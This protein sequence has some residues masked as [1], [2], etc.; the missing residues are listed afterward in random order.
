MLVK[1][2]DY[3]MYIPS[4]WMALAVAL[5]AVE[6]QD[7]LPGSELSIDAAVGEAQ[8]IVVA[9]AFDIG[10]PI[11]GGSAGVTYGSSNLRISRTLKGGAL[12]QNL[13]L[14]G[15][16]VRSFID[17]PGE[18]APS[19][20]KEYIFFVER[21]DSSTLRGIK[22]LPLTNENLASLDAAQRRVQRLPGSEFGIFEATERANII[23]I[24]RLSELERLRPSPPESEI[25]I[26]TKIITDRTLKGELKGI[27]LP[28]LKIKSGS[29]V[30]AE[31]AP[32]VGRDYLF[33]IDKLEGTEANW[34]KILPLNNENAHIIY[35]SIHQPKLIN[36][37]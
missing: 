22:L 34:F 26:S 32:I 36:K 3:F 2:K 15:F 27:Q 6:H 20:D 10:L 29:A 9:R 25:F 7:P 28:K 1:R 19:E 21:Q 12:P 31:Q 24:G 23:I 14:G 8:I 4:I 5:A 16:L 33:F 13:R 37:L 17:K 30:S 18:V 11:M 35:K